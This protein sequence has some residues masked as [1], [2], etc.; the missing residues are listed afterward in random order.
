MASRYDVDLKLQQSQAGTLFTFDPKASQVDTCL[1][2]GASIFLDLKSDLKTGNSML[3]LWFRASL[4][5]CLAT[6][7]G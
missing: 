6:A 3:S 5:P 1:G 4:S 2:D 7:L